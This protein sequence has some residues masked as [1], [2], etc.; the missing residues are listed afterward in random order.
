M[1][2]IVTVRE[3]ADTD[4]EA[5]RHVHR[6][7]FGQDDEADL[8]DALRAGGYS[9]VS[10][11]AESA[12][13]VVGHVLFGDLPIRTDGGTVPALSLAPLAVLPEY[14]RQGV[15]SALVRAG[16]EVCR[17]RGHRVVVVLGHPDYYPRFG[18]SAARAAPLASPFSGRPAWMAL[19]LVPGALD[20]VAGW[21]EY[22][23]PF[24]VGPPTP[25][26]PPALRLRLLEVVGAFA[27]CRLPAGS[28][29]P[30]WA[31][32]GDLFSVT[33]TVDEVSVVCHER[34]VPDGVTVERAWRCLRV[35]G[36]MPF[37]AVGV[38]AAL[39]TPLAGAGV[40]VFAVSTYDT[41][42]LFV[43][44]ADFS[45]AVAALRAAGHPVDAEGAVP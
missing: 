28:P 8:V 3:E 34:F 37:T 35:A 44:E 27:V 21:A 45:N 31:T 17:A 32:V 39:T 18:F 4:H 23:P 22:P 10:L 26:R 20:G 19:E 15:G 40:G 13:G 43:K 9:R 1:R 36:A 6:L 33:R 41:D 30:P 24:G 12:G 7:A 2:V 25:P 42:Y 29:V 11:V 38:L 16:L 5:V 14:Q